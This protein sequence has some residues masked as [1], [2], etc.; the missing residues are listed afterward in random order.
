MLNEVCKL[1]SKSVYALIYD[2]L[3]QPSAGIKQSMI[4]DLHDEL[5]QS[6]SINYS[7]VPIEAVTTPGRPE[8]PQLVAPKGV[9]RRSFSSAEGRLVLMHSFAHIEFNAINL[10]LD[11]AYRFQHMPHQFT[12][13]WLKVAKE[14]AYHFSLINQYLIDHDKSYGDYP[15]HNGLWDMVKKTDHDVLHRMGLVP[16]VMEARGLDVTPNMIE[17]FKKINDQKAVDILAIIYQDEIG[18]VKIGNKW[19]NYCCEQQNKAP[20]VVFKALIQQYFNGKLRGPFNWPA[21]KQAGFSEQEL[22]ELEELT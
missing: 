10:A 1:N 19:F 8:R 7:S 4:N 5:L 2:C 22:Q 16:R 3:M 14:E 18:H 21:R 9:K 17:R 13:D 12:L 11:A 6:Q 15:A 20:N